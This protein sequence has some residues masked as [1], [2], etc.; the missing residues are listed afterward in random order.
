[1]KLAAF[2]LLVLL[3]S[4][5]S[6]VAALRPRRGTLENDDDDNISDATK[7]HNWNDNDATE[8][9]DTAPSTTADAAFSYHH[10]TARTMEDKEEFAQNAIPGQ[11]IV[12]LNDDNANA[13]E[14]L[15]AILLQYYTAADA[16]ADA[17]VGDSP[18]PVDDDAADTTNAAAATILWHYQNIFAGV[19]MQGV[20]DD[21][22]AY[23][24]ADAHVKYVEPVRETK[25]RLLEQ[26]DAALF[27]ARLCSFVRVRSRSLVAA[28]DEIC[29]SFF[30]H[31]GIN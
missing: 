1:M 6:V 17:A 14:T 20:D 4:M 28:A 9:D 2:P 23:L 18:P 5:A 16:D 21:L 3:A 8:E 26:H 31:G 22:R 30:C 7:P 13:T 12:V 24:Q 29:C 11:Y 19:T 10:R 25:R 15:H 27:R